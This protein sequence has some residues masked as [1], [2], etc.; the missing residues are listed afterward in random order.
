MPDIDFFLTLNDFYEVNHGKH[1]PI[2]SFCKKK[3][4][5]S[6]ILIPDCEML[7]GFKKIEH[8]L[9]ENGR[10]FPW[11][12]K[13]EKAFWRGSTTN[14]LYNLPVWTTYPRTQLTFLSS[15]YPEE[16][17]ARFTKFIQGATL[18][19]EFMSRKDLHGNK[20]SIGDSLRYKYLID[21]DGNAS[22]YSRFY[23]IL[24]SNSLPLKQTSDFIQWYYGALQPYKH[25]IP[26]NRDCSD[27][28][29]KVYW[30][31]V[32]DKEVKEIAETSAYFAKHMLSTENAYVY[33][34]LTLIRYFSL[35]QNQ[36]QG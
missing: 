6:S 30:A 28:V 12:D 19:P 4:M 20:V 1:P 2:L 26:F 22:T 15:K 18:N 29:S 35:F 23:W 17:N 21:I 27:L 7:R 14:G 16:I 8:V 3:E 31:R 13:L 34:Y 25:F 33:L 32:H 11:S 36:E 24:R 10:K 5:C 9:D